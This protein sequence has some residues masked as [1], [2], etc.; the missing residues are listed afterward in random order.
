[1]TDGAAGAAGLRLTR[2]NMSSGSPP[3]QE[4]KR[5]PQQGSRLHPVL[6]LRQRQD[7]LQSKN[8]GGGWNLLRVGSPGCSGRNDAPGVRARQLIP[9]RSQTV[10]EHSISRAIRRQRR[11][12]TCRYCTSDRR[13]YNRR[14][15]LL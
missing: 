12:R 11:R 4:D 6:D 3:G 14:K 1:V 13:L 5:R 10:T 15:L 9:A 7:P 8:E 2:D